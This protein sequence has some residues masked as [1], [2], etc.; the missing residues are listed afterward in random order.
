MKNQRHLWFFSN[1]SSQWA[2]S[3][4]NWGYPADEWSSLRSSLCP[5]PFVAQSI[6]KPTSNQLPK[7]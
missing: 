1:N 2:L 6:L 7:D 5:W 4:A 3:P